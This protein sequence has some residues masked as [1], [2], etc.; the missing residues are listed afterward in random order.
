MY[1]LS[2]FK[3]IIACLSLFLLINF[4]QDTY[5][6]Y[7]TQATGDAN[8]DIS[9]WQISINNQDIISDSFIT[10]VITPTII[11]NQHVKDG[12]MAPLSEGYFDLVIDYTNVDVSFSYE[13][14]TEISLSSAVTDLQV[15]GYSENGGSVIPLSGSLDINGSVLLSNPVRTKTLRIYMTWDDSLTELMDNS[16]DTMA[17]INLGKAILTVNLG[18]TQITN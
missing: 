6:K 11:T 15:T 17:S 12:T 7:I 9:R 16:D 10:N 8:V 13:V 18:F 3:L 5:A 14:S 2:K 4:V 1:N